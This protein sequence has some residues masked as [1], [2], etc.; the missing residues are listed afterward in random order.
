MMTK[1]RL[2]LIMVFILIMPSIFLADTSEAAWG[3]TTVESAGN[4]GQYTSIAVGTSGAVYIS[5]YDFTNRVLMYATNV[6]GSW[7]D[8]HSG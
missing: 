3:T 7:G 5:Y 1:W 4:K 2:L 8:D 6:S